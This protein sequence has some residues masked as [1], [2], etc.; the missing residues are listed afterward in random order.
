MKKSERATAA[1]LAAAE[2]ARL[3][4]LLKQKVDA[5]VAG[6]ER[7]SPA[8]N[9][10]RLSADQLLVI[11]AFNDWSAGA[12]GEDADVR[13][14]FGGADPTCATIDEL[15]DLLGRLHSN[16]VILYPVTGFFLSEDE[17]RL[18]YRPMEA[19]YR[20]R[21]HLDGSRASA[22]RVAETKHISDVDAAHQLWVTCATE[23][24]FAYLTQQTSLYS[25]YLEDEE[26]ASTKRL[27]ARYVQDRFSPAQIWTAMWRSVK[28]AAAL[29]KRE[30]YNSAKAAKTI[31]KNIDKVLNE[32]LEDAS[33]QAYDRSASRPVGAVL[34]LFRQ[35]FGVGDTTPGWKV[36]EALAADAALAPPD[37]RTDNK[38]HDD[39]G[40]E[41]RVPDKILAQG[42]LFFQKGS[43]QKTE[44]K[45]R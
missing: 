2:K 35:R 22:V 6:V 5:Y 24:C 3:A 29:S 9:F 12:L 37:D 38:G 41:G 31:P 21:P 20:L 7:S 39:E 26:V 15:S 25:L 18:H 28:Q 30:Y 42:T 45:A 14:T 40:G 23:D 33:L 1:A 36:K 27:V 19:S 17:Q 34:T 11:Q 8:M 43:S 10:D 4:D 16:Q 32:S 44:N 13:F